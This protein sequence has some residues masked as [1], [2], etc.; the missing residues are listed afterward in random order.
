MKWV[1]DMPYPLFRYIGQPHEHPEAPDAVCN[2]S[3]NDTK[4]LASVV[5]LDADPGA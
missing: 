1:R 2:T 4:S 5:A 3:L